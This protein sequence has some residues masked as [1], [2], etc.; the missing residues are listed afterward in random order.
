MPELAKLGGDEPILAGTP[1]NEVDLLVVTLH[2]G[3]RESSNEPSA[4]PS[5]AS[6]PASLGPWRSRKNSAEE[7]GFEP[8]V[9]LPLRR[10]SKPL[11]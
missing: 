7:K 11:P 8:L 2:R 1:A 5:E 6:R 10:F 4:G 9:A 3:G